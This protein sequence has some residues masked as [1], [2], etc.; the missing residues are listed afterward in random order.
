MQNSMQSGIYHT[1]PFILSLFGIYVYQVIAD[2]WNYAYIIYYIFQKLGT[3]SRLASV[4]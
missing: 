3:L 1:E 4:S 2:N